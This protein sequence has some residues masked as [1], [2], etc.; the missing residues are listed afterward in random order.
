MQIKSLHLKSFLSFKELHY[1]FIN[2][3]ALIQGENL[4]EIESQES[5]GS[6]KSSFQM[7]IEYA[8]FKTTIKPVD[9]D[10][11]FWGDS[12]AEVQ[13]VIECPVRGEQLCIKR[14]ISL[15]GSSKLELFII[16]RSGVSSPLSFATV[17]DGN[18]MIIDWIGISKEDLRNYFILTKERYKSFFT[19]SN[20]EKVEMINRFSNAKIIDGVDKL[21]Q[22]DVDAYEQELANLER[23]KTSILATIRTLNGQVKFE[24][25]RDLEAEL[26]EFINN[27][28]EEIEKIVWDLSENSEKIQAQFL[29]I[30]KYK[31][32]I[33][34]NQSK[35][36]EKAQL[37]KGVEQAVSKLK[38]VDY[39]EELGVVGVELASIESNRNK[40]LAQKL[41]LENNKKEIE[42][43][44]NEVERNIVGSVTC[45][46]CK[47]QFLVGDPDIDIE[48]EKKAQL[49]TNM[50][51]KD[52][53]QSINYIFE[54]LNE[55]NSEEQSFV[56][57]KIDIQTKEDVLRN[58][59][60]KLK[61]SIET[62]MDQISDLNNGINMAQRSIDKCETTI[63]KL[64]GESK[65]L[66]A[67]IEAYELDIE[68]AKV[69]EIDQV[70][71]KELKNKMRAE[72]EKLRNI[73][74]TIKNKKVQI[75]KTG[76]WVFNFK[77][78]NIYL[79]N[80]S[81]KVIQGHCNK[82]LQEIKSDIQVQ[83]EGIKLL[84][85]GKTLKEEITAYIL[86]NSISKGF[87]AYSGGE[88]A[89]LDYSMILTMQLMINRTHKYGGLDFLS[90]DEVSE[91]LDPLGLSKLMDSFKNLNKTILITTHVTGRSICDNTILIR[92]VN[93]VSELII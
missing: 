26:K 89:R 57:Q 7:A 4:T 69:K 82:F 60:R 33:A 34:D 39:T 45:P 46:K 31:Q 84:A 24:L 14:T 59:S 91:G 53:D 32:Q 86:R 13:L 30:P 6:G 1:D 12:E 93:G 88:R 73:N 76:Q 43:I 75:F 66:K 5:N 42:L 83:W 21:V 62:I 61:N 25:N 70:R 38:N 10:L 79:A 80:Q 90:T 55:L 68:K 50:I 77:R 58:E 18:N 74:Y 15:K 35:I 52:V 47:H 29:S 37:I 63:D 40:L 11:I 41:T 85:D 67:V 9:A 56:K 3:P 36:E 19:S 87:W 49:E 23:H 22:E 54:R 71:V 51:L 92:K 8:I 48:D 17:V 44:L 27:V 2:S 64:T 72:G 65:K 81:L 16:N 78:F 20:K 28:N